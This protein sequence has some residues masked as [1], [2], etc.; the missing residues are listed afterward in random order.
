[1]KEVK[2]SYGCIW[3][4]QIEQMYKIKKQNK[5]KTRLYSDNDQLYYEFSVVYWMSY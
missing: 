5:I 3:D 1:M 4:L 2:E